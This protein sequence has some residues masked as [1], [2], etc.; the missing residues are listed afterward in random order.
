MR[1]SAVLT[2]VLM[3]AVLVLGAPRPA[4]A[5]TPFALKFSEMATG[6]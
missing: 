3:T 2:V 4:A 1:L 5:P 6:V